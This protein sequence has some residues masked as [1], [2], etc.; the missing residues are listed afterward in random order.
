[1]VVAQWL[2][3]AASVCR[4]API[5]NPTLTL[6]PTLS[7]SLSLTLTLA[8]SLALT[9]A[10]CFV[11]CVRAYF[12]GKQQQHAAASSKQLEASSMRV[13]SEQQVAATVLAPAWR[14]GVIVLRSAGLGRASCGDCAAIVGRCFSE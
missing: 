12:S 13:A 5:P 4:G 10:L 8:L 11:F 14:G 6:T 9:L 1:M 7:L 2:L 3:T